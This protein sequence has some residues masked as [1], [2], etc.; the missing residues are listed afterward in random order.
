MDY[1][2]WSAFPVTGWRNSASG[3]CDFRKACLVVIILYHGQGNSRQLCVNLS[4]TFPSLNMSA[5]MCRL[6]RKPTK[7][8]FL[9]KPLFRIFRS[10]S[11]RKIQSK[12]PFKKIFIQS[13]VMGFRSLLSHPSVMAPGNFRRRILETGLTATW[14]VF[15]WAGSYVCIL[16]EGEQ[17]SRGCELVLRR[18]SQ[19]VFITTKASRTEREAWGITERK[20]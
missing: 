10:Y 5:H 16:V 1:S 19:V 15:A 7:W 11:S 9:P 8:H 4:E 12:K 2:V 17:K 3:A 18:L 14:S 13:E 6:R 20:K